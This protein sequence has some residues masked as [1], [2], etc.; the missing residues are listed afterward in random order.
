MCGCVRVCMKWV[1]CS[2]IISSPPI[3]PPEIYFQIQKHSINVKI[4]KQR[5]IITKINHYLCTIKDHNL[6]FIDYNI[7][8]VT[9]IQTCECA[10]TQTFPWGHKNT[11]SHTCIYIYIYIY[12]G[13]TCMYIY[14]YIY[15]YIYI[16][17]YIYI[18]DIYIYILL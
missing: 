14:I 17:I 5:D 3:Q 11:N 12:I 15:M 4:N 8:H 18:Y 7:H 10:Q 2:F 16:Y 13:Y 1:I 6:H 9:H